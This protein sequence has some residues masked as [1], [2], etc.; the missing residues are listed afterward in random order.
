MGR[1][2][3]YTMFKVSVHS[4]KD[5]RVVMHNIEGIKSGRICVETIVGMCT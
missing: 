5:F 2:T 3:V 1:N 4:V